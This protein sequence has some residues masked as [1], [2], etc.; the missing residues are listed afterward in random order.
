MHTLA[1]IPV[2]EP[3]VIGCSGGTEPIVA[4]R[5]TSR[6]DRGIRIGLGLANAD[7]EINGLAIS[8]IDG[9]TLVECKIDIPGKEVPIVLERAVRI[10]TVPAG[11]SLA[12]R[13]RIRIISHLISI[14]GL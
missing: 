7:I 11:D 12:R 4:G 1:L 8:G 3:G 10:E 13:R 2:G 9:D 5:G 14:Y 6:G